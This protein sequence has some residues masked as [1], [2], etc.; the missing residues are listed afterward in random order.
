MSVEHLPEQALGQ[1]HAPAH[2]RILGGTGLA[3]LHQE[4][5]SSPFAPS[6]ED[7]LRAAYF[8]YHAVEE[9]VASMND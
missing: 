6:D 3:A 9:L 7:V 1:V 5:G 4:V 8:G 2:M